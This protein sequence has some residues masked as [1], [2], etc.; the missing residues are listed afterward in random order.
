MWLDQTNG[1]ITV[2]LGLLFEQQK[3]NL[4]GATFWT[5]GAHDVTENDTSGSDKGSDNCH[6]EEKNT[7]DEKK[8]LSS[9]LNI[10]SSGN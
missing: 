6:L 5:Y 7:D 9:K 10:F 1:L 8:E 3:L 2:L 4:N